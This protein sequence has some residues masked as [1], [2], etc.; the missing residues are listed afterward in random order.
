MYVDILWRVVPICNI[1]DILMIRW[2]WF[3]IRVYASPVALHGA[4]ENRNERKSLADSVLRIIS[5]PCSP[6]MLATF[7]Q[8]NLGASAAGGVTSNESKVI[9]VQLTAGLHARDMT[10]WVKLLVSTSCVV[11]CDIHSLVLPVEFPV[12]SSKCKLPN[13]S[14]DGGSE[15]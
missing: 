13:L 12:Q 8:M 2:F 1:T 10:E 15:L 6:E 11:V 3:N 4:V 5:S 9:S 14:V 7:W